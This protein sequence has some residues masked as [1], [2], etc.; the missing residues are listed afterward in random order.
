MHPVVDT[1]PKFT[2]GLVLAVMVS[3]ACSACAGAPDHDDAVIDA[4]VPAD[5]A[6]TPADAVVDSPIVESDS[7]PSTD[8]PTV[9]ATSVDTGMPLCGPCTPSSECLTAACVDGLCVESPIPDGAACGEMGTSVCVGGMCR[10][11]GCGDGWVEPGPTPMREGCDDGNVVDDDAC[12]A[13]CVPTPFIVATDPDRWYSADPTLQGSAIGVDGTGALLF[14]WTQVYAGRSEVRARRYT[15]GGV[16]LPVTGDDPLLIAPETSSPPHGDP[17]VVGLAAGGWVVVWS[18]FGTDATEIYYRL[19]APDGTLGIARAAN[20]ETSSFQ[21]DP[22]VAALD[23]GFVIVWSDTD[24]RSYDPEGG[25]RARVFDQLGTARSG[26]ILVASSVE[27]RQVE[28]AVAAEGDGFLVTW[29]H[30]IA[31]IG[32]PR[33]IYARRFRGT[34][35]IDAEQFPVATD[36]AQP[37]YP[38]ALGGGDYVIAFTSAAADARGDVRALVVR[39]GTTP[40]PSEAVAIASTP[41]LEERYPVVAPLTSGQFVVA[42]LEGSIRQVR[43]GASPGATLAMESTVLA[44]RLEMGGRDQVS[45]TRAPRGVWFAFG[46]W[47]SGTL[48]ES[49][50]AFYLPLD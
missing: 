12:S 15:A 49:F 39:A 25:V 10:V 47:V 22:H 35:P 7:S 6:T 46:G 3:L 26:E 21:S 37:G 13:M 14:V 28:P 8:A 16:P 50:S 11:R 27:G 24:L 31:M 23:D 18:A 33:P 40:S 1:P 4:A 30:V 9:D 43:F 5:D 32:A 34:T 29:A 41:S 48:A 42:W 2:A 38:A 44:M 19:V 36:W 17:S 45:L 20:V